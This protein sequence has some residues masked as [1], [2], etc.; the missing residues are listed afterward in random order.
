[1]VAD[2]FVNALFGSTTPCNGA[3]TYGTDCGA[4]SGW[5]DDAFGT[6]YTM[7]A[8]NF[9]YVSTF[10]TPGWGEHEVGIFAF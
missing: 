10:D 7:I 5:V 4:L 1:M 3:V 9:Y 2:D 8:D 6:S